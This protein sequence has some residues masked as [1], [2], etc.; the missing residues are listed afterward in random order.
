MDYSIHFHVWDLHSFLS[1]LLQT[2]ALL[3]G[4]FEIIQFVQAGD[5][6]IALLGKTG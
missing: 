1:F 4:R 5:E 6:I 2:A 3:E